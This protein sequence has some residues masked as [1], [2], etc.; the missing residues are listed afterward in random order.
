VNLEDNDMSGVPIDDQTEWLETDGRGGF[1]SGTTSGIRTRRYHALLLPALTPPTGRVALVNGFDAFV[2]TP[3]GRFAL[4]SQRYQPDVLH[5]EGASFIRAFAGEPWPT[6]E[7]ELPDGTAVRQELFLERA[8]GACW[9]AWTLV[10]GGPATL[11][12]RLFFSG[13]DYHALHRENRAFAFEAEPCGASLTYRPYD[14]VPPVTV[15]FDG[16]YHHD[17]QW[18]RGFLYAAERER[19]LDDTEDLASPGILSWPLDAGST[20]AALT[21]RVRPTCAFPSAM[22]VR[23][24]YESARTTEHDFRSALG[25]PLSR[26]AEAYLVGRGTGR[27]IV[28]GYPWFTDWGRDTF[29]AVR[30]LCLATGRWTEARDILLE[31]AGAVDHGMLPNRF[32]DRGEEPE[33]NA[34]DASLWFVVAV[35]ELLRLAQSHDAVAVEATQRD[36]LHA[37]VSAIVSGYADGTRFG[38]HMDDDGLLAAGVQGQQLTWMDA[39]VGDRE[40]TPRIGKPVEVQA[41]WYNAV[42][43]AATIE[44]R[45]RALLPRIRRAF[46]HRFWLDGRRSLADVVDVNHERGTRDGTLRPNQILAVGG[47]PLSL[48]SARD[49][50]RLV[51]LVEAELLTP[52]GLRSLAPGAPGYV[53]RYAGGSSERDAAYHQGTVWPWLLGPF[54]EAWVRTRGNTDRARQMARRRY[55][56][57]IAAHLR[58]A[59]LSHVS[60]IADARDPFTPRGCPFQAWSLG[61]YLRLDRVV[62]ALREPT[63]ATTLATSAATAARPAQRRR[64]R[65]G[66][67]DA[68]DITAS[69]SSAAV[70]S[71]G[72]RATIGAR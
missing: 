17:P 36:A 45:W 31:W 29:I 37:A 71:A 62:L 50:R 1:A 22:D 61:E 60:E 44:P 38:I 47:L 35:G 40:I 18:Y 52:M 24:A 3:A 41:L 65:A 39:R 48:V 53:E 42:A 54:V 8:S 55:F 25:S 28:A 6:W 43:V 59:G 7:Y 15:A 70:P 10:H 16:E 66:A 13:R 26:A 67:S 4:S 30:G 63:E 27:T 49:G 12:V 34:V 2:E 21:L 23:D 5:P 11:R 20:T 64:R 9:L 46:H 56:D 68:S 58:R 69:S 72:A 14:G 57:P 32:P 51:D 19:G 33:F